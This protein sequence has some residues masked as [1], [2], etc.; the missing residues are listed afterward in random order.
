M[1]GGTEPSLAHP[2]P[3][4][5]PAGSQS[6]RTGPNR[7]GQFGGAAPPQATGTKPRPWD[8]PDGPAAS[9]PSLVPGPRHPQRHVAIPAG[10]SGSRF[11]SESARP[12]ARSRGT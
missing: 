3:L 6:R 8:A 4:W 2:R 10:V 1:K 11:E 9:G 12:E 5:R 7:W